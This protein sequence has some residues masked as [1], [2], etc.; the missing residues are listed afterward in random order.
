MVVAQ[1]IERALAHLGGRA[2]RGGQLLEQL[3]GA[4]V[5]GL[6]ARLGQQ[7][8]NGLE[9]AGRL[10]QVL[11]PGA[12]DAQANGRA[13]GRRRV[14]DAAVPELDQLAPGLVLLEQALESKRLLGVAGDAVEPAQ[15]VDG[16][17]RLG[18][19]VL[20]DLVGLVEQLLLA[21][22]ID[23]AGQG[24]VVERE[25]LVPALGHGQ[26][27]RQSLER[28]LRARRQL[29]HAGEHLGQSAVI[30]PE[31]LLLKTRGA[32][33]DRLRL[34]GSEVAREHALVRGGDL[35]GAVE[36][37]GKLFDCVPGGVVGD[38]VDRVL[39]GGAERAGVVRRTRAG[40][41]RVCGSLFLSGHGSPVGPLLESE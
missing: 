20:G 31:P 11:E 25:Q 1:Q 14:L 33:A 18:R 40:V 13:L 8:A 3:A 5:R 7:Q 39:G 34:I 12:R 15:V 28:P 41:R 2:R 10:A 37:A 24:A 26:R 27:H 29:E 30:L 36:L 17:L 16:L 32:L 22:A 35:V 23:L 9:R 6:A 38:P 21:R 4:L 19:Q